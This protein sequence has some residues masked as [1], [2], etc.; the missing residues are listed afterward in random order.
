MKYVERE[1]CNKVLLP[2]LLKMQNFMTRHLIYIV[3]VS[4]MIHRFH[5]N[6]N[7]IHNF[8]I[9]TTRQPQI[10]STSQNK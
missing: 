8:L 10:E 7:I 2:R 4:L 1:K 9:N 3:Y 6:N 5:Q